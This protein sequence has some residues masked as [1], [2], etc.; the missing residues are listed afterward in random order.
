MFSRRPPLDG[1]SRLHLSSPVPAARCAHHRVDAAVAAAAALGRWSAADP[2]LRKRAQN[3]RSTSAEIASS[4]SCCRHRGLASLVR[5]CVQC[6]WHECDS[7]WNAQ[8]EVTE[9]GNAARSCLVSKVSPHNSHPYGALQILQALPC[10]QFGCTACPVPALGTSCRRMAIP[11]HVTSCFPV[12]WADTHS[13]F[14]YLY[15]GRPADRHQRARLRAGNRLPV[16]ARAQ[17]REGRPPQ[18]PRRGAA[19]QT[20]TP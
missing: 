1:G 11:A 12:G 13:R 7:S 3:T 5:V 15:A 8:A 18:C 9:G 10:N 6:V 4:R 16:R 14:E 20:T 2:M 17:R 19:H